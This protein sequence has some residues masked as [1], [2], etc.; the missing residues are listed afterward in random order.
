MGCVA[1]TSA[2]DETRQE[3]T[4][5]LSAIQQTGGQHAT[6][7][8]RIEQELTCESIES[9]EF[10]DEESNNH[11]KTA[12]AMAE[13]GSPTVASS[14]DHILVTLSDYDIKQVIATGSFATV[15]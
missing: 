8:D 3:K 7:D 1:S 10:Y 9:E 12:V 5:S 14:V 11:K 6:T 13:A 15:Q 4:P 2:S